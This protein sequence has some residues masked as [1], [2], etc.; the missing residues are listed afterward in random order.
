MDLIISVLI[1]INSSSI[2]YNFTNRCEAP[3]NSEEFCA[4]L[5]ARC[6]V[7]QLLISDG[8]NGTILQKYAGCLD[9]GF[10]P[11]LLVS[12]QTHFCDNMRSDVVPCMSIDEDFTKRRSCYQCANCDNVFDLDHRI[13]LLCPV[14]TTNCYAV[15]GRD[16]QV[17]RGCDHPSDPYYGAC[18]AYKHVCARC[19]YD[20]CNFNTVA[21]V[22]GQ[23]FKTRPYMH[24]SHLMTLRLEDC[25]GRYLTNL[26]NTCYV[27]FTGTLFIEA[28]CVNELQASDVFRYEKMRMGDTSVIDEEA[29]SCYK[30][31]SNQTDFCYNVRHL[32]PEPCK[33]ET[34][35]AIRGCY[36]MLKRD[37]I[38]RGCLT[39]LDMY[40]QHMCANVNFLPICNTC[41]RSFCNIHVP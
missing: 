41:R 4:Q 1:S 2:E 23:C 6:Y 28:G 15:M 17:R 21:S 40:H 8:R 25:S 3:A 10:N 22:P 32:E 7:T 5:D 9:Y 11:F 36:T 16:M 30:C 34:Q 13:K 29:V 37:T 39:E 33:F 35:Y 31:T 27:A 18:R 19:D 24:P 12:P 38:Q 20:Y 14:G 26:W